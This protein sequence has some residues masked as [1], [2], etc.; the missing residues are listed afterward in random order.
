MG[1]IS[2]MNLSEIKSLINYIETLDDAPWDFLNGDSIE[3]DHKEYFYMP[4]YIIQAHNHEGNYC[5]TAGCLA[6]SYLM[7]KSR[8]DGRGEMQSDL[9]SD[10]SDKDDFQDPDVI[11][12]DKIAAEGLGL[13]GEQKNELFNP[14]N[15]WIDNEVLCTHH[16]IKKK[17]AIYVLKGL[18]L[19]EGVASSV[20]IQQL[21]RDAFTDLGK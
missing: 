10:K 5:G 12:V 20:D 2:I 19:L 14:P 1:K 17:H 13:N 21:W 7:M 11:P 16:D 4:D 6:G 8:F 18:L 9:F 15:I 3:A